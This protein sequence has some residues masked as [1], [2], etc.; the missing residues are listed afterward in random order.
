MGKS[1]SVTG[2]DR[3]PNSPEICFKAFEKASNEEDR[4]GMERAIAMGACN[5]GDSILP[6]ERERLKLIS[7]LKCKIKF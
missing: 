1:N 6:R 2:A 3:V 7:V 4:D 5:D